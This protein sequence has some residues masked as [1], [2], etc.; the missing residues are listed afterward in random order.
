MIGNE[1]WSSSLVM[2]QMELAVT[3]IFF[4]QILLTKLPFPSMEI[5]DTS[6]KIA[7]F[8]I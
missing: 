2:L 6:C 7:V 3:P 5:T 1:Q 8:S 4:T